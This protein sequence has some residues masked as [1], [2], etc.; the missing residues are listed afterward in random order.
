MSIVMR[1]LRGGFALAAALGTMGCA[2]GGPFDDGVSARRTL[3]ERERESMAWQDR[4]PASVDRWPALGEAPTVEDYVALALLRSAEVEAAHQRFRAAM[5]RVPQAESLPDPRLRVGGISLNNRDIETRL[6]PQ[7][8]RIGVSQ[9]IPWPQ[10]L[11]ARGDAAS[12]EALAAW[13]RF[14]G[15]R[16]SVERR[17]RTALRELAYLEEEITVTRDNLALVGQLEAVARAR[18]RVAAAGHPDVVRAQLELATL[19]DRVR[20]LEAMRDP[21]RAELNAALNRPIEAET[22]LPDRLPERVF[23]GDARRL[24]SLMH[25]R[26]AELAALRE[27]VERRRELQRAARMADVPE[28][29]LDLEYVVIGE[30]M[31]PSIEGSGDDPVMLGAS[32]NVPIWRGKYR[33]I[34]AEALAERLAAAS[35]LEG[36]SRQLEAAARRAL[37]RHA[38]AHRRAL[39]NERS[40]IPR[41][42]ESLNATLRAFETGTSGFL[43][44]IESERAL[45]GYRLALSRARADRA[46]ALAELEELAG[47][48]LETAEA[49]LPN[50]EVETPTGEP[51]PQQEPGGNET[52]GGDR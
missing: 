48:G 14:E 16:L 45:L 3:G 32:I 43:D 1:C 49:A 23:E 38:D 27:Q 28:L 31:D 6:G 2:Q 29:M 12:R 10:L 13:R 46:I 30:A 42:E 47:G 17:V 24:T 33:G 9:S 35:S 18:Y 11:R 34:E 51:T 8:A 19:E 52:D 7:E 25:E 4:R 21:V 50:A 20:E 36:R 44:L 37:F 41:A 39:L 40:L 22:P 5:A 15:E 26:N